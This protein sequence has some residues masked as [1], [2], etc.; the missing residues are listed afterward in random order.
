M[1]GIESRDESVAALAPVPGGTAWMG[2]FCYSPSNLLTE[3]GSEGSSEAYFGQLATDATYAPKVDV[4]GIADELLTA[5]ASEGGKAYFVGQIRAGD[6]PDGGTFRSAKPSATL[7]PAQGARAGFLAQATSAGLNY[8]VPIAS[9]REDGGE[10]EPLAVSASAAGVLVSGVVRGPVDVE[11]AGS[12]LAS[13]DG[14]GFLGQWSPGGT[15]AWSRLFGCSAGAESALT[16][17]AWLDGGYCAAVGY[18]RGTCTIAGTTVPGT[19]PKGVYLR[20]DGTAKL[21]NQAL[22]LTG[23]S[24]SSVK[25]TSLAASPGGQAVYLGGLF[26]G[27]L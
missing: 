4:T 14:V 15:E 10:V 27:N 26:S 18:H 3:A 5:I 7:V 23:T 16:G 11:D 8:A 22:S 20:F 19:T 21:R 6:Y 9:A 12:F 17:V 2:G 24:P 13:Q 1:L 25:V